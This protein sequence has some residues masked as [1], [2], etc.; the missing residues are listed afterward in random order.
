MF[1]T[2]IVK[3]SRKALHH[4]TKYARDVAHYCAS[5]V[6]IP[7]PHGHTSYKI[8]VVSL[9]RIVNNSFTL[10][11]T[12]YNNNNVQHWLLNVLANGTFANH[13]TERRNAHTDTTYRHHIKQY[14]HYLKLIAHT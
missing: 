14:E 7:I 8:G 12:A 4:A 13:A 1:I 5:P 10:K 6:T 11:N 9:I 3:G 2:L